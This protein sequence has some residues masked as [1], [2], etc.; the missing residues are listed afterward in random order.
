MRKSQI[1]K[2]LDY[3]YENVR[4][5]EAYLSNE[6]VERKKSDSVAAWLENTMNQFGFSVV[7]NPRGGVK[8]FDYWGDSLPEESREVFDAMAS[9]VKAGS[10]ISFHDDECGPWRLY[11]DGTECHEESA[12]AVLWKTFDKKLPAMGDLSL[13]TMTGQLDAVTKL[14]KLT[15]HLLGTQ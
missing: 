2:F 5:A 3:L 11:F 6:W 7:L 10:F 9:F 14:N 15:G 8:S 13:S 4:A 1:P 12:H